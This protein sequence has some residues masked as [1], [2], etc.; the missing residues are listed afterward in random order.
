MNRIKGVAVIFSFCVTS[1]LVRAQQKEVVVDRII[2]IVGDNIIKQSE[3]ESEYLQFVAHSES[4][5]ENT[6][7]KML[8]DILYQKLLVAQAERDSVEV[9]DTQ[10]DSELDRRLRYYIAQF[11]SEE[12][13]TAFYGKTVEDYK[14]ELRDDVKDLLLA[15]TMQSKVTSNVNVTP[16]EVKKYFNNIPSDSL[17][18]IN[19]EIEIGEIVKKPPITTE[20]KLEAKNKISKLRERVLKG[21][22]F[23]SLAVLYSEDPGSAKNGGEYKNIQRG[24]FVPEF[25]AISFSMKENQFSEVFETDYGYHFMQLIA[26]RG[27][28]VDLKHILITPKISDMDMVASKIKLDSIYDLIQKDSLSF[29]QAAAKYSDNDESKNVNGLIVNPSTGST[30]FEMDELGQLDPSLVFT[31]DKLKVGELAKPALAMTKDAKQSYRILY[32]K[33]R[34]EPHRANLRDDYQKIQNAALE[35]KKQK[36]IADWVNKKLQ[37]TYVKLEDDFK[38]CKFDNKWIN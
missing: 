3:L 11:G 7:C 20:A 15:Q 22:N 6:R 30:K 16:A 28:F 23:S 4:V 18:F 35:E 24:Q 2:A 1:L 27:E 8:E 29:E 13:F 14:A 33:S 5:T 25:D 36:I 32:L 31:I 19:A 37:S 9:T 12:S 38:T 17:P 21:E 34:T 26:R 10:V